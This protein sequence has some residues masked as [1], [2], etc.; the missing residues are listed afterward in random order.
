MATGR[1][2]CD[3]YLLPG[4]TLQ[5]TGSAWKR[6]GRG[7]N[8]Y[9][10][11]H[12]IRRQVDISDCALTDLCVTWIG[13]ICVCDDGGCLYVCVCLLSVCTPPPSLSL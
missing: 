11:R 12:K 9:V 6:R 7:I 13:W 4:T 3:I 5:L 1:K 10:K 8:R 2:F